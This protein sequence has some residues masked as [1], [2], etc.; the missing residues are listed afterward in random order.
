[1][2]IMIGS[3]VTVNPPY[4]IGTGVSVNFATEHF[5]PSTPVSIPINGFGPGHRIRIVG[6]PT[7]NARRFN[8]NLNTATETAFH[9]NP[10]FDERCVVRN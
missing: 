3:G 8:V 10:R 1:T 4:P 7:H 2:R 5:N 9:F 6:M